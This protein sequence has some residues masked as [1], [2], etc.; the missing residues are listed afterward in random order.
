ML[1]RHIYVEREKEM[2]EKDIENENHMTY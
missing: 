2:G 1:I